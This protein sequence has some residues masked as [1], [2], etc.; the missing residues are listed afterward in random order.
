MNSDDQP[1]AT[2]HGFAERG[3]AGFVAFIEQTA[4][5]VAPARAGTRDFVRRMGEACACIRFEDLTHPLRF[6]RQM[7]G[8]PP[9]RFGTGGFDPTMVDDQNP[10]RHYTAFVVVGYWLPMVAALLVLYAWE[11]AGFVRYKGR[12]SPNDVRSGMAGLRHGRAVRREGPGV[13][14]SLVRRDLGTG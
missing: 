9:L 8:Q 6:L 11:V 4:A 5:E 1:A 2:Y 14:A 13:L 3:L 10:A 7:A 12:W